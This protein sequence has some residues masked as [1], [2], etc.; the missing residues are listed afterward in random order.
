MGRRCELQPDFFELENSWLQALQSSDLQTLERLL[1]PAFVCIPWNCKGEL[2]LKR[3]YLSEAR[4]APFRGCKLS[5]ADVQLH[6]NYALVCC[7]IICEYRVGAKTWELDII[8]AD[9]WVNRK[10]GWKALNRKATAAS[11]PV[12]SERDW[13][14]QQR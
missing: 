6:G 13:V 10:E 14:V 1:D 5:L 3:D 7:R 11:P 2:L 4:R 8:V 12:S 9:I